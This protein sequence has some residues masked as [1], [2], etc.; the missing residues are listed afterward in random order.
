MDEIIDSAGLR[1]SLMDYK[2]THADVSD[3]DFWHQIYPEFCLDGLLQLDRLEEFDVLIVD[4]AQDLL[5][6]TYVEVLG[7]VVKGGLKDGEW[8]LFLDPSQNIFR[9]TDS[10]VLAKLEDY[11]PKYSS[12]DTNCRNTNPIAIYTQLLSGIRSDATLQIS[13]PEVEY[14][15]YKDASDQRRKVSNCINRLLGQRL[16]VSDIVVLS[17]HRLENSCLK[18]GLVNVPFGLINIDESNKQ[19]GICYSTIAAFKGLESKVVVYIDIDKLSDYEDKLLIY[20]G[21][22]RAI[23]Y[24]A[25]FMEEKV[26]DDFE[27]LAL[28][29]DNK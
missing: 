28:N 11:H 2:D 6:D 29:S 27:R 21:C 8:R 18:D 13:G 5:R 20:V 9:G 3:G 4:E 1:E 7:S 14:T 22:S 15:W 16:D 23:S 17:R 26:R 24:L 10:E 25:V 19:K 12:L